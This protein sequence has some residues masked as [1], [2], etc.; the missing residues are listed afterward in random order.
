MGPTAA[1]KRIPFVIL[2]STSAL[3]EL[4]KLIE[5]S[6]LGKAASLAFCD[7]R[8]P[9]SLCSHTTS[10]TLTNR[11]RRRLQ[12][13]LWPLRPIDLQ[14]IERCRSI[15]LHSTSFY[16]IRPK[17][18]EKNENPPTLIIGSSLEMYYL[19]KTFPSHV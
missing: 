15:V 16:K 1:T 14:T 3:C 12:R 2:S 18:V 11:R 17:P 13:L 10:T 9:F 19:L 4:R 8:I 6:S 7:H 5:S